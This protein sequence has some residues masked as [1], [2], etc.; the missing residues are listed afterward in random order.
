MNALVI[1]NR[2]EFCLG[3]FEDLTTHFGFK[4]THLVREDMSCFSMPLMYDLVVHLGSSWSLS[5]LDLRNLPSS[6]KVE[7]EIMR[8]FML[9]G[10]PIL[11]V[12]F[13]AQ[14]MSTLLGGQVVLNRNPEIGWF[15]V[16]GTSPPSE[17]EGVWM[18][19]HYD[20]IVNIPKVRQ[21]ATNDYGLQAFAAGSAL[22]VQFHPEANEEVVTDWI[23]RGGSAELIRNKTSP[24]MLIEESRLHSQDS[25]RRFRNLIG[26]FLDG[27][28]RV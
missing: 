10:T 24:E 8:N 26:A 14:L 20:G 5:D 6:I 25:G 13:G 23:E 19:W 11:G 21:L 17:L 2:S 3:F 4:L 27:A 28:F 7:R 15:K 16:D 18:Q 12:C 9:A 22:G 1:G